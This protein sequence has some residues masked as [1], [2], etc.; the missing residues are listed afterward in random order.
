MS[1][2]H[3]NA[4]SSVMTDLLKAASEG[5]KICLCANITSRTDLSGASLHETAHCAAITH[6]WS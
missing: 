6:M 5:E 2:C 3:D 4:E 1:L